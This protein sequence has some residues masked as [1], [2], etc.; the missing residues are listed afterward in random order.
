MLRASYVLPLKTAVARPELGAYLA[1]LVDVLA[2]VIVVDGSAP[3]VVAAHAAAWP[4]A[5]RHLPVDPDLRFVSGKVNGVL[6]GLRQARCDAVVLADDDVRYT[7]EAL[8]RAVALLED[9]DVVVPQNYFAPLPWHAAWDT[10]RTL[11]NRA[12]AFDYP[13]TLVVRRSTLLR[14]G[15]YDGDVLFENLELLRT[16]RA[17]GGQVRSAPELFV[18]REPPTTRHFL[19]QRLRQAYD[20]VAQPPRLAAELAVVPALAWLA[21]RRRRGALVALALA[22]TAAAEVGRRRN[23]GPE[24][25]PAVTSLYAPLWLLER[26]VCAWGALASRWLLGGVPYPGVGRLRRA[27]TPQRVLDARLAAAR[28]PAAD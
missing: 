28:R 4:R 26:G 19:G 24:V 9:A 8:A 12:V 25:F 5:V 3:D 27:A 10:A 16:V 22:A 7:P 14:A 15:G 17:V 2:D 1:L 13:G 23:R 20:S 11:L 18:R 21:V 6:T